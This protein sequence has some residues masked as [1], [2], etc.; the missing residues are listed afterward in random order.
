MKKNNS[1]PFSRRVP[2]TWVDAY[3]AHDLRGLVKGPKEAWEGELLV[4]D[5]AWGTT[6][7][8][9]VARELYAQCGL[10]WPATTS[11]VREIA[12]DQ[13]PQT[14][15]YRSLISDGIDAEAKGDRQT[16]LAFELA[17]RLWE[18]L[19]GAPATRILIIM[20]EPGAH[21]DQE[22]QYFIYFLGEALRESQ[23]GLFL[24]A[25]HSDHAPLPEH[26]RLR[27]L[28][29][30]KERE[31]EVVLEK[32]G[33]VV[34][35]ILDKEM[36]SQLGMEM[37]VTGSKL[38]PLSNGCFL[39]SPAWRPKLAGL[40]RFVFDRL[41]KALDGPQWMRAWA[42]VHG[43]NYFHDSKFTAAVAAQNFAEGGIEIGLRQL[44]RAVDCESQLLDKAVLSCQLQGLRISV[45][46]FQDAAEATL[47]SNSLPVEIRAVLLQG[48]GWGKLMTKQAAAAMD[49]FQKAAPDFDELIAGGAIGESM[50]FRNIYALSHL[51]A[52]DWEGAF[53][54]EKQIES[55]R[56]LMEAPDDC[57]E[58]INSINIARLLKYRK[59]YE[60]AEEYFLR[61]FQTTL[62]LRSYGDLIFTN[63]T[64][65]NLQQDAGN[66]SQAFPYF[67]RAALH[68]LGNPVP[69]AVNK[70]VIDAILGRGARKKGE[71]TELVAAQLALKLRETAPAL[72]DLPQGG[73]EASQILPVFEN[74]EALCR[75]SRQNGQVM[76]LQIPHGGIFLSD[77]PGVPALLGPRHT[78][79]A[80][81]AWRIIQ[82]HMA[83][84]PFQVRSVLVDQGLWT[85]L[86]LTTKALAEACLRLKVERLCDAGGLLKLKSMEEHVAAGHAWLVLS[87]GISRMEVEE[88]GMRLHF[89][90]YRDS[91][92]LGGAEAALVE[93]IGAGGG[94][95]LLTGG[96]KLGLEALLELQD[97]GIIHLQID[98]ALCEK[99]GTRLHLSER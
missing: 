31:Q 49:C 75:P 60:E 95:L 71:E 96:D 66:L 58:Y 32:D 15:T 73:A 28:N 92:R 18:H 41:A 33:L 86:P 88:G 23:H 39:L 34:P 13:G 30:W 20:P 55:D 6:R 19:A 1:S 5:L 8:Q 10:A 77:I 72:Y 61:A 89:R 26:W 11:H 46:K 70:R 81:E 82:D 76:G 29:D 57:L 64:L 50:Y 51:H 27:W 80:A 24:V 97:Q 87:P 25:S 14:L 17:S 91:I 74:T 37:A 4:S 42:F 47:P 79:L 45:G 62:G 59:R 67:F 99:D 78:E 63:V 68:W 83:M 36:L 54:I 98:K 2:E 44:Q 12:W 53:R 65:G 69:E 43:N 35:G 16:L 9:H 40:S 85:E 48:I 90:R 94:P 22:N 38:W 93:E 7:A 3:H 84:P 21:W 52:G 56:Q